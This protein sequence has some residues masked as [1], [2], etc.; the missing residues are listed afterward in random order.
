MD[1][2]DAIP[3]HITY[4]GESEVAPG[5]TEPFTVAL[6]SNKPINEANRAKDTFQFEALN[7]FSKRRRYEA[8]PL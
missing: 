3:E 7:V 6:I 2:G 1:S 8:L 5:S 4:V